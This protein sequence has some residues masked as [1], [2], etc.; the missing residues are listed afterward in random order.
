[1]AALPGKFQWP[2]G[3]SPV[4]FLLQAIFVVEAG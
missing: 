3:P 4:K 1:M 2:Y